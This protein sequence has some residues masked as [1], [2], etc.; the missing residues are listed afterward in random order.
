MRA[1]RDRRA[2]RPP[3][4]RLT[5]TVR[6]SS[7]LSP[8]GALRTRGRDGSGSASHEWHGREQHSD[9]HSTTWTPKGKCTTLS[10]QLRGAR[11]GTE[12][13]SRHTRAGCPM[14]PLLVLSHGVRALKPLS[15]GRREPRSWRVF[16]ARP[17]RTS[18]APL[19]VK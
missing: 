1:A 15:F 10:C 6:G 5:F 13:M 9:T 2:G 8:T 19:D 16:K 11:G 12:G 18:R 7:I 4:G 14:G 3:H 17:C